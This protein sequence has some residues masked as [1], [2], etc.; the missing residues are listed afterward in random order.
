[1]AAPY[2]DAATWND[3]RARLAPSTRATAADTPP[4][5]DDVLDALA[6]IFGVLSEHIIATRQVAA[7]AA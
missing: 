3:L 6:P 1:M 4:I 5:P 2:K 7:E